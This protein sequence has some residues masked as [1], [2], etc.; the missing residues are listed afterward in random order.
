LEFWIDVFWWPCVGM[1]VEL[2][3]QG[4]VLLG[5]GIWALGIGGLSLALG[6]SRSG[7]KSLALKYA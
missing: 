4:G 2:R 6:T 1:V 3:N 5:G 7:E